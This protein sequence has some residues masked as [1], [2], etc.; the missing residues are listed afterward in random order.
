MNRTDFR[1]LTREDAPLM[2]ALVRA[3]VAWMAG[4]G[5]RQWNA[6]DYLESYPP[7]Y[8]EQL[9]RDGV[10]FGLFRDTGR[11]LAAGAL[12]DEDPRWPHA[13]AAYY[14]H[15][16]VSDADEPG[17][18]AAFLAHAE[19]YACLRGKTRLRLDCAADNAAL[20]AYYEARGYMAAGTCED[21]PYRGTLREKPLSR[22]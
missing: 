7:A 1:P 22:T 20:N 4:A 21:G 8:Y 3:R 6:T 15:H 13:A 12:F 10:L 17:A 2:A 18:G 19:R 16:F 14:L 9:C 5:I 11:L